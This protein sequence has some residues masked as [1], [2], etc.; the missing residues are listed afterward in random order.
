MDRLNKYLAHAGVGS[1][2]HCDDLIA[3]GRVSID[4]QTVRELGSR[5]EEGQR[6]AVDGEPVRGERHVYWL[7]HKPRGVLCTNYD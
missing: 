3:A 4:G 1:R 2:R 7:V 5:V 6:V